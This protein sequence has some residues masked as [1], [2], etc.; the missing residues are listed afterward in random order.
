MSG[1][2]GDDGFVGATVTRDEGLPD[3]FFDASAYSFFGTTGDDVGGLEGE[4]ELGLEGP[5]EEESCVVEDDDYYLGYHAEGASDEEDLSLASLYAVA[6]VSTQVLP[7]PA[8][9]PAPPVPAPPPPRPSGSIALGGLL[10]AG[11]DRAFYT[12]SPPAAG[13]RSLESRPGSGG[14]PLSTSLLGQ[15]PLPPEPQPST[16]Y[17]DQGGAFQDP[18]VVAGAPG[19]LRH[20]QALAGYAAAP[21]PPVGMT[22]SALEASLLARGSGPGPRAR[23][24]RYQ[25]LYM[26]SNEIDGILYTQWRG[27]QQGPPYVED[28]Y[29]QGFVYKYYNRKNRRFFAPESVRELAPT[30]KLSADQVAFVHLDGLGRVPFSNIRRPRPLMELGGGPGV[31]EEGAEA[32]PGAPARS[33]RRRLDQEPLLAA[34]IMIE[35]CMSLI[36]DVQD[37]DQIFDEAALRSRRQLLLEGL[38]A[39]LRLPDAPGARRAAPDPGAPGDAV[40]RRLMGLRKG[41]TLAARALRVTFPPAEERQRPLPLAR[42]AP[43]LR[44]L[45]AVLRGAG[46]LWSD[47]GGGVAEAAD[48]LAA[49]ARLADAAAEVL[50]ALPAARMLADAAVALA[51]GLAEGTAASLQAPGAL[52][53][54]VPAPETPWLGGVLGALCRRAGELRIGGGGGGGA[55]EVAPQLAAARIAWE[56]AR[57]ALAEAVLALEGG[58][59]GALSAALE[60]L[61]A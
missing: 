61:R 38:S 1:L 46:V 56:P 60:G 55:P 8:A 6:G 21:P 36:L 10:A 42:A 41:R 44:L 43:N 12:P 50:A 54:P 32:G 13:A 22:A 35:D 45:W 16:Y 39:S 58:E 37:I 40:F 20:Q 31:A 27:L 52:A 47:P 48:E 23:P 15:G 57:A 24:P 7:K 26:S 18:S 3:D 29:F 25:S 11:G 5:P 34:R 4:L 30:E 9:E 19:L 28:Y 14:P 33:R 53:A 17:Q 51:A 2:Q 49:S 59:A